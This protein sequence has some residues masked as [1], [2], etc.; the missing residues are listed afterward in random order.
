MAKKVEKVDEI[1]AAWSVD[2]YKHLKKVKKVRCFIDGYKITKAKYDK[3]HKSGKDG[4]NFL[5]KTEFGDTFMI[6]SVDLS[7]EEYVN[8][9][10]ISLWKMYFEVK[11]E[12]FNY[13]TGEGNMSLPFTSIRKVNLKQI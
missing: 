11:P 1:V 3:G 5:C 10:G 4:V 13:T 2:T 9:F 12:E 7:D 6:Y 8:S